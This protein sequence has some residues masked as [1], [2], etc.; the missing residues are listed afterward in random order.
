MSSKSLSALRDDLTSSLQRFLMLDSSEQ[1]KNTVILQQA[2]RRDTADHCDCVAWERI[3]T[4]LSESVVI[5]NK[6]QEHCEDEINV[7]PCPENEQGAQTFANTKKH[8]QIFFFWM[9]F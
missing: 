5:K 1:H 3:L 8:L 2:G 6:P 4:F 9:E 7:E